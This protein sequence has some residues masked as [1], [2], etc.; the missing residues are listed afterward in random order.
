M[1]SV[2]RY[3]EYAG[4]F[5]LSLLAVSAAYLVD[6]TKPG[7]LSLLLTFP[8]LYG[9]V[10]SIST[11]EFNKASLISF[12]SLVLAPVDLF[13]AAAAVFISF[14]TVTV[15]FFSGGERFRDFY[16]S[17]ALPLLITGLILSSGIYIAASSSPQFSQ[18]ITNTTA[19]SIAGSTQT[20]IESS[21]VIE[22]Q[23]EQQARIV[24]ATSEN[25]V[26]LTQQYV[27][28]QTGGEFSGDQLTQLNQAFEGA[29]NEV[30]QELSSQI[31][32]KNL[33]IDL[34]QQIANLIRANF[35]GPLLIL[36]IPLLTL[37]V[38]SLQPLIGLLTALV[39][40]VM[41][42]VTNLSKD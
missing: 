20:V 19:N 28:N 23:Q 15:S 37:I 11:E 22:M 34:E 41:M 29:Q 6:L 3:I 14:T 25:T 38:Y 18:T 33:D 30:P 42:R 35:T 26:V 10:A 27:L 12:L 40:S 9:F 21:G 16:G 4:V 5:A 7:T 39:A 31:Q 13:M 8:L 36:L 32:S 17:T 1:D 24:E 2:E